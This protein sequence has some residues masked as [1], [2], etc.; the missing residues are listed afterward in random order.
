[1][2]GL[3]VSY[4]WGLNIC[5]G[6]EDSRVGSFFRGAVSSMETY[7]FQFSLNFSNR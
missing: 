3:R 5:V 4:L 2:W 1:M 6:Q 7:L